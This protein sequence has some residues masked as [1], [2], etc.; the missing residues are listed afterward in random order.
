M[1]CCYSIHS[2]FLTA[3]GSSAR[4]PLRGLLYSMFLAVAILGIRAWIR[5]S[6]TTTRSTG[7]SINDSSGSRTSTGMIR[8]PT[9]RGFSR[10]WSAALAGA[11]ALSWASCGG[12]AL[13]D[14]LK[15]A[16]LEEQ[17]S[18]AALHPTF[19]GWRLDKIVSD[20]QWLGGGERNPRAPGGF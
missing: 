17:A 19:Y 13:H 8:P 12:M 10:A 1:L 11:L 4:L 7:S 15:I 2:A 9:T 3:T 16:A 20:D 6:R 18:D 14:H 5:S